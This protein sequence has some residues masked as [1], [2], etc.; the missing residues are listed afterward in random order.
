[1]LA[2]LLTVFEYQGDLPTNT[3]AL[4]HA[5]A[6]SIWERERQRNT[7]GWIDFDA[8]REC[9]SQLA[10]DMIDTDQS[11]DVSVEYVLQ[12]LK[13]R[14]SIFNLFNR[15]SRSN[16]VEQFLKAVRNAGFIQVSDGKARFTHQ[17]VQEYF[18]ANKL[19]QVGLGSRI[20]EPTFGRLFIYRIK[21]KWDEVVVTLCGI[22]ASPETVLM[23]VAQIDIL[24]AVDCLVSGINVKDNTKLSIVM[25]LVETLQHQNENMRCSA[26]QALGKLGDSENV[27]HLI[28]LLED[29][30]SNVRI[31][32]YAVEA[33]GKIGSPAVPYLIDSLKEGKRFIYHHLADA[34]QIID[35]PQAVSH[36]IEALNDPDNTVRYFA[37]HTLGEL[38]VSQALSHLIEALNDPDNTVR[39]HVAQALGE[40]GDPQAVPH[41]INALNDIDAAVRYFAAWALGSIGDLQAVSYLISMLEDADDDVRYA[42]TFALG[43]IG[44]PQAVPHLINALNDTNCEVRRAS[45]HLLG[46]LGNARAIPHLINALKDTD[47]QVKYF[48]IGSLGKFG[49]PQAIPHLIN[50]LNDT[51][52]LVRQSALRVLAEIAGLEITPYFIKALSDEDRL[53]RQAAARILGEL[54]EE[55]AVQPL[56]LLLNDKFKSTRFKEKTNYAAEALRQIGTPQALE[57]VRQWKESQKS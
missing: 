50:T 3:G 23:A 57:A 32:S 9:I 17:L 47:S 31:R 27:P 54:G 19:Y 1:M 16:N 24:L 42:S 4:F 55:K 45:A 33:L 40:I 36:V 2:A 25:K 8:M 21:S 35:D 43:E 34:L 13:P 56:S 22:T 26:I 11:L 41:L 20:A 48:S 6:G 29:P 28:S 44:D 49:D 39:H 18:A 51:S 5:L 14:K 38:N 10:F 53:V 52:A 46:E 30:E 15:S 12:Q 7:P 37:A